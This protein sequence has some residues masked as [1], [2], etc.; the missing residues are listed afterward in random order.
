MSAQGAGRVAVKVLVGAAVAGA[1]IV[2]LFLVGFYGGK[3]IGGGGEATETPS[4]ITTASPAGEAL[5]PM[6]AP[7][8]ADSDCTACHG[9]NMIAQPDIPRMAHPAEGW[10]NCTNC[11]S[12]TGLVKTAPG[13]TG[14]HKEA[15]LMCHQPAAASSTNAL[16]RPHHVVTGQACTTCHYAGGKAP[17]PDTMSSR[18]NCWVCHTGKDSEQLFTQG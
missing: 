14:I 10:T 6:K 5:A 4:A 1:G 15:C 16:P 8:P 17:L 3:L 18:K 11:H 2:V 13:H 7:V 9:T 12:D